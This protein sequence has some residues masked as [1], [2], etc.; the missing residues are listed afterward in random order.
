V[1]GLT[2]TEGY[3]RLKEAIK[4]NRLKI[5]YDD[6]STPEDIALKVWLAAPEV[7]ARQYNEQRLGRLSRFDY[8]EREPMDFHWSN[9]RTGGQGDMDALVEALDYWFEANDRGAETAV[10]EKYE[11]NGEEWYLVRHGDSLLRSSRVEKRKREILHYRPEKDDVVVYSPER[12]ELRIN[13]KTKGEKELYRVAFGCYLTRL[14]GY[15]REANTYTLEPLRE[16]GE[17]AL[18]CSDIPGLKSVV[19]TRLDVDFG[20][21]HGQGYTLRAD[22]VFACQWTAGVKGLR[23][24]AGARLTHAAFSIRAEGLERPLDV[25]IRPPNT[26]RLARHSAANLVHKWAVA[27]GFKG[28]KP[29]RANGAYE[30]DGELVAV[31]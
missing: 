4:Q 2:T 31:P 23:L 24:P 6:S 9:P 19:L 14:G 3:E 15:F 11:F 8:Y 18:E 16:L 30:R 25:H 10:I 13:A 7:M 28:G 12:D 20:N 5:S 17:A 22:D 26:L 27:R 29:A 21:G 1:V